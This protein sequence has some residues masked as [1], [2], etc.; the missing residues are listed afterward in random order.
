MRD[1]DDEKKSRGD[2]QEWLDENLNSEDGGMMGGGQRE[3]P[4]GKA[5]GKRIIQ[6]KFL[7]AV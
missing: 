4:I 5:R 2:L 7:P 6:Y 1:Y 3:I